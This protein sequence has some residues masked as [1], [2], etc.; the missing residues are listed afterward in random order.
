MVTWSIEKL[1]GVVSRTTQ[2]QDRDRHWNRSSCPHCSPV[3]CQPMPPF[4]SHESAHSPV[5]TDIAADEAV[6]AISYVYSPVV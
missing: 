3:I 4:H 2:G 6:D 1:I 5:G